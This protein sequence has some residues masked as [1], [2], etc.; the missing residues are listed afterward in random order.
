MVHMYG[1]YA[2]KLKNIYYLSLSLPQCGSTACFLS[3]KLMLD[4]LPSL[5]SGMRHSLQIFSIVWRVAMW[6]SWHVPL[7]TVSWRTSTFF[8][9]YFLKCGWLACSCFGN[10]PSSLNSPVHWKPPST[11]RQCAL[12]LLICIIPKEIRPPH[13]LSFTSFHPWSLRP[14]V[15]ME[16]GA[17]EKFWQENACKDGSFFWRCRLRATWSGRSHFGLLV[18][19]SFEWA[20]RSLHGGLEV[21]V[22]WACSGQQLARASQPG[23]SAASFLVGVLA[24]AA[25]KITSAGGSLPCLVGGPWQQMSNHGCWPGSEVCTDV[26]CRFPVPILI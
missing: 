2:I 12:P 25:V 6:Y 15:P 20:L 22:H 1:I 4:A 11:C 10:S 21:M 3:W 9:C 7:A 18:S 13:L 8:F 24:L 14:Q 5:T 23:R 16:M 26:C 19:F 17:L